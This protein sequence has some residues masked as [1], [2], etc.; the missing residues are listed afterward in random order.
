[1]CVSIDGRWVAAI[2]VKLFHPCTICTVC[3]GLGDCVGKCTAAIGPGTAQFLFLL[4][5]EFYFITAVPVLP[6]NN[7]QVIVAMNCIIGMCFGGDLVA[8]IQQSM[9]SHC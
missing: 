1:M 7:C 2:N 5:D 6:A 8:G 4:F 9:S 3:G